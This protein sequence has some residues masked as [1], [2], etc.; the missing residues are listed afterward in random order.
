MKINLTRKEMRAMVEIVAMAET[1]LDES[2]MVA[3]EFLDAIDK[4]YLAAAEMGMP[5]LIEYNPESKLHQVR[6]EALD[7]MEHH[8]YLRRYV[9]AQMRHLTC[10]HSAL[11]DM[12]MA[13]SK[14]QIEAMDEETRDRIFDEL[15]QHYEQDILK[16]LAAMDDSQDG[17][18]VIRKID[19]IFVDDDEEPSNN[20]PLPT[21]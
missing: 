16:D 9:L 14:E 6:D 7:E 13:Y 10:T 15:Y 3:P 18:N 5:D 8:E 19:A 21:P 11:S 2:S 20:D 17:E 1:V 12:E 4:V